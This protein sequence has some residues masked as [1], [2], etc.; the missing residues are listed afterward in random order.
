MI[1][2]ANETVL[3]LTDAAATLPRRRGGRRVNTATLYR[4]AS[5]GCRGVKLETIQIGGTKCTS[6]EA[7]RRFFNRLAG[8]G[9]DPSVAAGSARHPAPDR[10]LQ[11]DEQAVVAELERLGL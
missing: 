7:L 9:H 2:H 6:Q 10:R 3:S 1:D 11:R 4:W 5:H 8:P